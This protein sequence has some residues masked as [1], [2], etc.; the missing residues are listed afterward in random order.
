[1]SNS[2]P[3]VLLSIDAQWQ[4]VVIEGKPQIARADGK[5]FCVQIDD[6]LGFPQPIIREAADSKGICG[7]VLP[8]IRQ[9]DGEWEVLITQN[10]RIGKDGPELLYE[11]CRSSV[12]NS[13]PFMGAADK[14]ITE[15]GFGRCNSA[16]IIG[17]IR[18]GVIDV[19][20]S[21]YKHPD[22]SW[23]TFSQFARYSQDMMAQAVLFRFLAL[24]KNS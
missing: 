22:G 24:S 17:T 20:G 3:T 2:N 15:L 23:V 5:F 8:I 4:V 1:M 16:R 9:Q 11:A 14:P 7:A 6:S 18:C 21:D 13:N 10:K 19:S 12:S